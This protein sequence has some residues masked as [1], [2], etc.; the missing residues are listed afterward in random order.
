[1]ADIETAADR[2]NTSPAITVYTKSSLTVATSWT[3]QPYL[4]CDRVTRRVNGIDEAILRYH[5]GDNVRQIGA[6]T[7][8]AAADLDLRGKFVK[9][10]F[11]DST[12]G[13]F[14]WTGYIVD[15]ATRRENNSDQML[16]AV[17]LEYFLDRNQIIRSYVYNGK[18][19]GRT[20]P[21]N[22]ASGA[23]GF[24]VKSRGNR[25]VSVGS[26]GVYE[27]SQSDSQRAE[28]TAK[29]I[30]EYLVKHFHPV[31]EIGAT[32]PCAW[33][34]SLGSYL[35]DYIVSFD[36]AGK[37]VFEILNQLLSPRRSL[38]WWVEYSEVSG[39]QGTA[40]INV[41]SL[42]Q[43]SVSLPGGGGT[44]P[45]NGTQFTLDY[46]GDPT[47]LP[48]HS[49]TTVDRGNYKAIRAQGARITSTFTAGVGDAFTPDW[50]NAIELEYGAGASYT[51]G[52]STLTD[53]EKQQRNDAFRRDERFERVYCTY[54]L[55]SNWDGKS[56]TQWV[57]PA[58]LIGGTYS[59]SMSFHANWLRLLPLTMLAQGADYE[60]VV[61]VTST[62]PDDT[63]D[64]LT[65]PFGLALVASSPPKYQYLDKMGSADFAAGDPESEDIRTAYA[66]GVQQDSPG[67][68]LRPSNGMNHML[69]LNH[70]SGAASGSKEPEIDYDDLLFTVTVQADHHA[71]GVYPSTPESG[72]YEELLIEV[73]DQYRLDYLTPGTVVRLDNGD[74][75]QS[76]GGIIR[77]DR[78]QLEDIAR[79]AYEW[80]QAPK[81]TLS[82]S[83]AQLRTWFELGY[84][85]TSVGGTG[86]TT[87]NT[88]VG[89]I[90]YDLAALTTSITT[91][92]DQLNV[93]EVI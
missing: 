34:S 39:T 58:A 59:A 65:P 7:M 53:E 24:A 37:T 28:W 73:G 23:G 10:T 42:N 93:R 30:V 66:M 15:E 69:A 6:T 71:E 12:L 14:V 82:V 32:T 64:N 86:P 76:S 1:M 43:S 54:R 38:C 16:R 19:I 22:D 63:A 85:I 91:I 52:Y 80:Y 61:D 75:V 89:V 26:A 57:M 31:T 78:D 49:I 11:E 5:A 8:G 35:N 88:V 92:G 90:S 40:T 74:L 72:T 77:D 67:V 36:P 29:N 62:S 13:D 44:L 84:M 33:A 48:G 70:W 51:E 9:V 55:P 79:F 50:T 3:E 56:A 21:F 20:V 81:A 4:Y 47:V 18:Q 27:F 46:D 17:G 41:T 60:N 2:V 87:L 83:W 25:S 68:K 45:A